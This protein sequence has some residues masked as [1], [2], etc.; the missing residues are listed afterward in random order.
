[1]QI[2][3]IDPLFPSQTFQT[4]LNGKAVKFAFQFNERSGFWG[5][6][7]L[8]VD[9]EPI[10]MGTKVTLRNDLLGRF[11]DPRIPDGIFIAVDLDGDPT[12][13]TQTELGE[14]V[15]ISFTSSEEIAELL[16]T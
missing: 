11:Q 12:P 13:P 6:N 16:A 2:I 10:I 3:P 1:M 15:V 5:F 9:D 4:V 7:L 8:T 14:R